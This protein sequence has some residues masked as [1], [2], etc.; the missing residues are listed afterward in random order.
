[1]AWFRKFI[2]INYTTDL[3]AVKIP[4]TF[5]NPQLTNS[6]QGNRHL[7]RQ[8]KHKIDKTLI[9]YINSVAWFW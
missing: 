9:K 4:H 6:F 3:G 8:S 7:E 5:S 1:M 2:K